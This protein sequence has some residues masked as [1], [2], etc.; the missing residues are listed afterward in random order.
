[1]LIDA[2]LPES[3][4]GNTLQYAAL[5]HNMSH[6]CLLDQSTPKEAWSSNKPDI[7]QLCTFSYHAFMHI[8]DNL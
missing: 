3:Y 7:S 5:L 8:P 4:W 2:D 1:M 6:S